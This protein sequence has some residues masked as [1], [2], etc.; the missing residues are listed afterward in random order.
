MNFR[1]LNI[2]IL[3]FIYSQCSFS[4]VDTIYS[5]NEL[6]EYDCN[7]SH[8][9]YLEL[10]KKSGEFHFTTDLQNID[11][12]IC[13]QTA[14][15]NGY[16]LRQWDQSNLKLDWFDYKTISDL[17]KLIT[18]ILKQLDEI[19][20]HFPETPKTFKSKTIFARNK[21]IVFHGAHNSIE[22]VDNKNGV[23]FQF[24]NCPKITIENLKID[25]AYHGQQTFKNKKFALVSISLTEK[26]EKETCV[27]IQGCK[28]DNPINNGVYIGNYDYENNK[29][30]FGIGYQKIQL[31]NNQITSA[32]KYGMAY[33]RGAHKNVLISKNLFQ[34][35]NQLATQKTL[36][37]SSEVSKISDHSGV[38]EISNNIFK[39][40]R[41]SN[42]FVQACNR[43]K[44]F[45]NTGDYIG[46]SESLDA[47]VFI[48]IDDLC[49]SGVIEG[50]ECS[51]FLCSSGNALMV[52][53]ETKNLLITKNR[54]RYRVQLRGNG[55]CSLVGND[56]I[57]EPGT[58]IEQYPSTIVNIIGRHN[59]LNEVKNNK[60]EFKGS[61][62][63]K[64][65]LPNII[66]VFSDTNIIANNT[67]K[68]FQRVG[69]RLNE[70][71]S[72]N[73]ILNN[74]FH[75][76]NTQSQFSPI[77]LSN[78]LSAI[79]VGNSVAPG[80]MK[81]SIYVIGKNN[82]PNLTIYRNMGFDRITTTLFNSNDC[83]IR[84]NSKTELKDNNKY[85]F[86]LSVKDK[87]PAINN[88]SVWGKLA[89]T[90][91]RKVRNL[92]GGNKGQYLI[93]IGDGKSK[94]KNGK[95]IE[96]LEHK[97]MRMQ[98][99]EVRLFQYSKN[100]WIEIRVN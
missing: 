69:I 45:R 36:S 87:T 52:Q 1:H 43:V 91:K 97:S 82:N 59:N 58:N 86:T 3:L 27:K 95:N 2:L 73:L 13:F 90:K 81:Q 29:T 61:P 60:F 33:I 85:S 50:N 17:S 66:E 35:V 57:I 39:N 37:I 76:L 6:K 78:T 34:D 14:Q 47:G 64:G 5:I 65:D 55:F 40:N 44:I 22:L 25:G 11:E 96:L 67:F 56:F 70:G 26:F 79:V 23:L 74:D 4:T 21:N 63:F 15:Q 92:E 51:N 24:I 84:N 46:Y 54:F 9:V 80:L 71:T 19:N 41:H 16:W 93:V 94:L 53:G 98:Q 8:T 31:N 32:G 75:H 38:V 88:R 99:N 89:N 72:G 83:F 10:G 20:I 62:N 68:G 12:G 77:F 28:I 7:K 48:K 49:G 100:K 42:I 18:P 30:A